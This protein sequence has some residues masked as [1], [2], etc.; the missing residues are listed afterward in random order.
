MRNY[1]LMYDTNL[2]V[3]C[4]TDVGNIWNVFDVEEKNPINLKV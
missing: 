3:H 1:D 2:M 4:F